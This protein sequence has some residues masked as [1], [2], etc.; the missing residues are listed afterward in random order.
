MFRHCEDKDS[1]EARRNQ[2]HISSKVKSALRKF[3]EGK[4]HDCDSFM[5]DAM[6][7]LRG[8]ERGTCL[9]PPLFGD[10]P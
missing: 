3:N 1:I 8:G 4:D 6:V 10:P 7:C 5:S 9:G 2:M